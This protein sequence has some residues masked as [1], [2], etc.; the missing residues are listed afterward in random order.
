MISVIIPNYNHAKFLRKRLASILE[1]TYQD[2]EVIILDDCSTD[3]SRAIIE[4]YRIHPL[5]KKI[6]YNAQ[7]S[8]SPFIQWNKGVALAQGDYVWIAE[9]DDY[10]DQNM[11]SSCLDALMTSPSS[12]LAYC[13]SLEI[14]EQDNIA[15]R[16]SRWQEK[17]S[18]N[19]W[20]SDFVISG[21]HLNSTY[22]R[23]ANII[24]NASC[25]LFRRNAY[26]K[27]PF[28]KRIEK[29]KCTGDWL[30][31]FSI[32]QHTNVCYCH[33]PL[34]YFRYHQATTRSDTNTR[35][36]NV[37]EHYEAIYTLSQMIHPL[38]DVKNHKNKLT[39]LFTSWNPSFR[40]FWRKE[41]RQIFHYAMKADPQ[42]I[43]RL[44]HLLLKRLHVI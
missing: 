16:W 39:E 34:N 7:N 1:Q 6:I 20:T 3:N 43:S 41:N 28:L 36:L 11:L 13:D 9:S 18:P 32:L 27:S 10:A 42:I 22:N 37:K 8:G 38:S 40:L 26:M 44:F 33:R 35:L 17:L 25:V 12:D 30:M 21:P 24:P 2:L 23:V 15:G 29:L 5:V 4:E 19:L 14:D 31:W